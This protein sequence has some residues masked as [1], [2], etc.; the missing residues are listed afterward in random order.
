MKRFVVII[1]CALMAMVWSTDVEARRF[2][3]KGGMNLSSTDFKAAAVTGYEVGLAWQFDLP[4]WFSIQPDL[5]YS[6]L[7][8]NVGELQEHIGLGYV[9]LPVNVQ[10]GPRFMNKNIRVFAQASPFVGYAV[11]KDMGLE[12][13]D[14]DR[15]NYGASLGVG[16]QLWFFQLIAQYNWNL[17]SLDNFKNTSI[18]DFDKSKVN[19]AT[20]GIAFMFGKRK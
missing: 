7:G 1:S 5:V 13:S 17:G 16:V 10:W 12:W 18:K 19:G 15:F 3:I 20:I 14:L 4:L 9:K 8:T 11:S 2:G 6:V